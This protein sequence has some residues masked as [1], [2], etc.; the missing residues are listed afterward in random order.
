MCD[1]VMRAPASLRPALTTS[2]GF[3]ASRQRAA[4]ARNRGPSLRPS[5]YTQIARVNGSAMKYSMK[6]QISRSAWLPTETAMLNP[7]PRSW[8]CEMSDAMSEPLWLIKPIWPAGMGSTAR[9]TDEV[10]ANRSPGLMNPRQLGPISRMPWLRAKRT[11]SSC[12]AIPDGPDSAKSA[13]NTTHADT[14]AS[15]QAVIVAGICAAGTA[16]SAT[17]IGPGAS[18]IRA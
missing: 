5:A 13:A 7:V 10:S 15:P 18:P 8:A 11:N 16:S 14:P 9:A 12:R 6:S 17:S 3:L 4:S 2:N 1:W